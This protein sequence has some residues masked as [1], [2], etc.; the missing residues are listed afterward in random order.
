MSGTHLLFAHSDYNLLLRIEPT[1]A[2][3]MARV[4]YLREHAA[5]MLENATK[6]IPVVSD[7]ALAAYRAVGK[8]PVWALEND[9]L[10]KQLY[11]QLK[12]YNPT[13]NEA[14]AAELLRACI[15]AQEL[16]D[17]PEFANMQRGEKFSSGRQLATLGPVA[18]KIKAHLIKNPLAN[19]DEVWAALKKSP[20]RG[21]AFM[22]TERF[23]KYIEKGNKT[24]MQWGRFR[25]L[26]SIHRPKVDDFHG[27]A[28]P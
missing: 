20:P 16:G 17:V 6:R 2:R 28:N 13:V 5:M 12:D 22:E 9:V 19:P 8:E 10:A 27:I 21:H 4:A 26:V 14:H 24:A 18:K 15:C 1:P 23:G 7:S 25:N 3:R 11:W